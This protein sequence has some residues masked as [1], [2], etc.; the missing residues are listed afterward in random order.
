MD[1]H[2]GT[3]SE[4]SRRLDRAEATL[5]SVKSSVLDM[6]AALHQEAADA[7]RRHNDLVDDLQK[8]AKSMT[9]WQQNTQQHLDRLTTAIQALEPWRDEAKHV[10][11][12]RVALM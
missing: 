1:R 3:L 10:A 9:R 2:V 12:M 4:V 5:K 8:M 11:E 7:E 6:A